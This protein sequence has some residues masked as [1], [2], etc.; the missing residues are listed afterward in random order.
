MR[1]IRNL[2]VGLTRLWWI[3]LLTGLIFVAFGI[4]CFVNPAT[5]IEVMAYL[6]CIG[7]ILAGILD[8]SFAGFNR[9]ANLNWGWSLA[10][11]ILEIVVGVW[12]FFLPAPT[13][14]VAFVFAVGIWMIIAA[15]NAIC[16]ALFMSPFIGGWGVF[17]MVILL[18]AT[19]VL[20]SWFVINPILGGVAVWLYLGLSLLA[21]GI[22]RI[23]LAFSLRAI[24]AHTRSVY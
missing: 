6:F 16:E 8:I 2:T 3:P 1:T 17:F 10:L 7:I 13:L 12:L 22:Y 11:G 23:A 15:I 19:L 18:I 20:A 4:W 21:F 14:A 9:S 24:N 5:S